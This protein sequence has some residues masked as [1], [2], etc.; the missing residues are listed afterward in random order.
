MCKLSKYMT[1]L[2]LV[3]TSIGVTVNTVHADESTLHTVK[4]DILNVRLTPSTTGSIIGKL[5]N[6]NQVNVLE[7][8]SKGWSKIEYKGNTAYVKTNFIIINNTS[9]NKV[10]HVNVN[11]L[12]VRSGAGTQFKVLGTLSHNQLVTVINSTNDWYKIQFNGGHA[13]V[14]NNFLT[15]SDNT[16]PIPSPNSSQKISSHGKAIVNHFYEVIGPIIESEA[17]KQGIPEWT[18]LIKAIAMQESSGNYVKY[19][20]V[21]QSSEGSCGKIRCITNYKQSIQNGVS[22]FKTRMQ[23]SLKMFNGDIR[24]GIQAYN[25]G[26]N[27]FKKAKEWGAT[28]Y[29]VELSQKYSKYLKDNYGFHGDPLYVQHVL[30]HYRN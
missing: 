2:V 15:A 16:K 1:T 29:S 21:M 3:G 20:D 26:P 14:K 13:Y 19:P 17:I 25:Y 18:E 22:I 6:G 4:A 7:K 5:F 23:G 12:N 30:S 11:K 8:T 10:F 28:E 9:L 24:M 27:F